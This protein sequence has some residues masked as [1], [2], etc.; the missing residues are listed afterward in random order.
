VAGHLP[1][2]LRATEIAGELNLSAN[3][4]KTHV[5]HL[6]QKLGAH[7]RGEDVERARAFGL[8]AS[9]PRSG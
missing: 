7:S 4:V 1:T 8:L 3:T 6:Y 9:S 2:H 5:R